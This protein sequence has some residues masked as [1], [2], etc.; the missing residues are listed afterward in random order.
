MTKI[1]TSLKEWQDLRKALGNKTIGFVPTMGNLHAGHA[2]LL[3]HSI[4]EN[5]IN[6][7]SVFVNPTQ[8]DQAK[9]LEKYPRT[10]NEDVKL[11]QQ[12]NIDFI[13]TP[14]YVEL[15][16]DNYHYKV[17]E[18]DFSQALCGK[19]RSGHFDG[20][21]TVVLKLL[22]L[23]KAN[24]AYFGEKDYQQ[25]HLIKNMV[26]AFF[27]DT[28]IIAC[29]TIRDQN[30]VALSSRNSRLSAEQYLLAIQ[31]ATLLRSSAE[32]TEIRTRLTSLG[33]N[34]DYIETIHGRRFGAVRIG[35][36]RL[37][38]NISLND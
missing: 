14:D 35:E 37:I 24:R 27:I 13:L 22:M 19:Y 5:E 26:N 12:L 6:I 16:P 36:V 4:S 8:F 7:L 18:T 32:D 17:I 20:V 15:Y 10:F 30:G 3:Q 9:D 38:D 11:A 31:F 2:S 23:I 29:K 34:V 28:Q 33:F 1:I 25:L 21:L